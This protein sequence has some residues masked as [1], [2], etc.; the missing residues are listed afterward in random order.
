MAGKPI[1]PD[2]DAPVDSGTTIP[3]YAAYD[4]A[5]WRASFQREKQITAMIGNSGLTKWDQELHASDY[6]L[7]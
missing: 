6:A 7:V 5:R 4:H 1:W 2:M 3:A